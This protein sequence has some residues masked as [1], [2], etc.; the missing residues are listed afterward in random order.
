VEMKVI[1][2]EGKRVE[3]YVDAASN[4]ILSQR[5]DN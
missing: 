5:L 2:P 1:T 4:T 3:M